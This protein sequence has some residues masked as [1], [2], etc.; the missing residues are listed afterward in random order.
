M[1]HIQVETRNC[2]ASPGTDHK[3]TPSPTIRPWTQHSVLWFLDVDD[4]ACAALP[5]TP[6]AISAGVGSL[7]GE[8][9]LERSCVGSETSVNLII[10]Y[11]SYTGASIIPITYTGIIFWPF[12]ASG[13]LFCSSRTQL[14]RPRRRNPKN[15]TNQVGKIL[16]TIQG[17]ESLLV[18]PPAVGVR[19]QIRGKKPGLATGCRWIGD[20]SKDNSD[21]L[22]MVDL[23]WIYWNYGLSS[24]YAQLSFIR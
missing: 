4:C 9:D 17:L 14:C 11:H 18:A 3:S 2:T 13:P 15:K 7:C 12:V 23:I 22:T 24:F 5:H 20:S 6:S 10:T 19:S 16:S 1:T 8:G 21:P